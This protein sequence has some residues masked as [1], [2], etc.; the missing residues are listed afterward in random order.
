MPEY[1]SDEIPE[2]WSDERPEY[3]TNGVLEY[4][5]IPKPKD[6]IEKKPNT[7]QQTNPKSQ[8]PNNR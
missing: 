6:Q 8:A 3:W 1:W 4:W 7:K 5:E 2:C